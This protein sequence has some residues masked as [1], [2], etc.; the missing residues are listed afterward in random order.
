MKHSSS[1]SN[2]LKFTHGIKSNYWKLKYTNNKFLCK[3]CSLDI[4]FSFTREEKYLLRA[5]C[6]SIYFASQKIFFIEKIRYP[7]F[8]N[9]YLEDYW[10]W[11]KSVI[12]KCCFN[13]LTNWVHIKYTWSNFRNKLPSTSCRRRN[14]ECWALIYLLVRWKS[15]TM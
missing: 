8:T 15:N 14:L 3:R 12:S 6:K 4:S 13:I 10:R 5:L 2:L 7:I 11:S 9:S 1:I